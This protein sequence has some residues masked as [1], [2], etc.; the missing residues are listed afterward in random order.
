M[1]KNEIGE[2][3]SLTPDVSV[4]FMDVL[5]RLKKDILIGVHDIPWP[6]DYPPEWNDYYFNEIIILGA[7]LMGIGDRIEYTLPCFY[8]NNIDLETKRI[9]NPIFNIPVLKENNGMEELKGWGGF[10]FRHKQ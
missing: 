9:L 4:F 7:Y 1:V 6:W 8:I 3:P 5:P 2:K 10:W